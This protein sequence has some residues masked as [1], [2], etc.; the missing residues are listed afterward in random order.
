MDTPQP[1]KDG[2]FVVNGRRM[3]IEPSGEITALDGMDVSGSR[4]AAEKEQANLDYL[5]NNHPD[6]LEDADAART[7]R[8]E[9][10]KELGIDSNDAV[11]ADKRKQLRAGILNAQMRAKMFDVTQQK[12][13]D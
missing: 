8:D 9:L 12:Q 11:L 7:R 4:T 13:N 2:V 10:N 5:I 6:R 3:R 1:D